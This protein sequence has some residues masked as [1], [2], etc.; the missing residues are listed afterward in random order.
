MRRTRRL[1][2]ARALRLRYGAAHLK[3][4]RSAPGTWFLWAVALVLAAGTL[5]AALHDVSTAW[6][7]WWYHM[8]FAARLWGI[9]PNGS[10]LFRELTEARYQ[11]FPLLTEALQGFLWRCL[12]RPEAAN[13]VSFGGFVGYVLFLQRRYG[14]PWPLA[15]V[16]LMAV[17]VVQLHATACYVDLPSNLAGSALVLVAYDVL[18]RAG[19][20]PDRERL[21][22]AALAGC[23]VNMRFQLYPLVGAVLVVTAP[24]V[25]GPILGELRGG[26]R[27]AAIGRI[28]LSCLALGLVFATPL[29]NWVLHANPLYPVHF[30]LAGASMPAVEEV[31]DATPPYLDRAPRVVLWLYS[32]LEIG[33]RPLSDPRRWTI[34][35]WMPPSSTGNM[36]GGYF[37]AYVV[38]QLAV[39]GW[40]GMR[41]R[42]RDVRLALALFGGLTAVAALSPQ[43]QVLRY[44]MYWM[45][46]LVSL[47]LTLAH[48]EGIAV[49]RAPRTALGVGAVAALAVV[50]AVTRCTYVYPSGS[51]FAGLLQEKVSAEIIADIRERE[52]ICLTREPWSFLYVS[53]FHPTSPRYVVQEAEDPDGCGAA[54]WIP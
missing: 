32:I 14:V 22:L 36:M 44:Y 24:R 52:R 48:R 4:P 17:P 5:A 26:E 6:D 47:N 1:R 9:V 27:R 41:D 31:F 20:I 16:A 28:A 23:A 38:F 13:L 2:A 34:D 53:A 40:I 51:S 33:I 10:Y 39:L 25:F 8:P 18:R 35:Q 19:P 50:L 3:E 29:K 30:P 46:V 45:I 49:A 54:R 7:V 37:G 42:S 43:P 21:L 15:F 12:G 11:G